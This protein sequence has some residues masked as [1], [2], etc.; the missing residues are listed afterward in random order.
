MAPD[1]RQPSAQLYAPAS[2]TGV[3]GGLLSTLWLPK[4][5]SGRSPQGQVPLLLKVWSWPYR[6]PQRQHTFSSASQ[7]GSGNQRPAPPTPLGLFCFLAPRPPPRLR[8]RPR[9]FLSIE[10][11]TTL[12]QPE[13]TGG[14]ARLCRAAQSSRLT[15]DQTPLTGLSPVLGAGS[16]LKGLQRQDCVLNVEARSWSPALT[17]TQKAGPPERLRDRPL[18]MH[19]QNTHSTTCRAPFPH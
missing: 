9:C 10:T 12:S 6:Q 4:G 16:W 14:C 3:P 17:G 2:K 8:R 15:R 13:W 1:P 18:P 11:D 7:P 5:P 19:G